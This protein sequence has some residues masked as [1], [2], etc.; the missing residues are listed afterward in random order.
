MLAVAIHTPPAPES[1]P[2]NAAKLV[3]R[4]ACALPFRGTESRRRAALCPATHDGIHRA[5]HRR[6]HPGAFAGAALGSGPQ[7]LRLPGIRA[8]TRCGV[9]AI[10]SA[11]PAQDV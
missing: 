6:R 9:S 4:D 3:S 10:A 8:V 5:H 1:R 2:E 7:R 11:E